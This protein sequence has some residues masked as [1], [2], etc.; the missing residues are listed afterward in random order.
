MEIVSD[1]LLPLVRH[2]DRMPTAGNGEETIPCRPHLLPS[3]RLPC[4]PSRLLVFLHIPPRSSDPS[5]IQHMTSKD[6][7]LH[8]NVQ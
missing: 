3:A 6:Q 8:G 2:E 4:L 1:L 7:T 5:I